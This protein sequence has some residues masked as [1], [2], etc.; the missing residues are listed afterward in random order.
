M[1]DQHSLTRKSIL[2]HSG[3]FSIA[4]VGYL[5]SL[6]GALTLGFSVWDYV[7]IVPFILSLVNIRGAWKGFSDM[8]YDKANQGAWIATI[9][10]VAAAAMGLFM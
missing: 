3:V 10:S 1:S 4:S 6:V 2:T 5:V 9:G 7:A 8:E